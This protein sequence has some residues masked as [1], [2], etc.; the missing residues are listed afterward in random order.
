M[1][2]STKKLTRREIKELILSKIGFL[3]TCIVAIS[4]GI[5]PVGWTRKL[6]LP[7]FL[8]EC[9]AVLLLVR[10][11]VSS[12]QPPENPNNSSRPPSNGPNRKKR[13]PGEKSGRKPGGRKGHAGAA[14]EQAENPDVIE[15]LAPEDILNGPGYVLVGESRRQ[16]RDVAV[17]KAVTG[18]VSRICRDTTAGKLFKAEFP[19]R[20]KAHVTVGDKVRAMAVEPR[21]EGR[22]SCE[23]LARFSGGLGIMISE[24]TEA[25]MVKRF[26]EC[27]VVLKADGLVFKRLMSGPCVGA[28]GSPIRAGKAK[29]RAHVVA[30]GLFFFPPRQNRGI[31]AMED[32]GFLKNRTGYLAHE[33]WKACESF[34]ALHAC[35]LARLTR[36]LDRAAE[37][38]SK[39]AGKTKG[40]LPG[41]VK[42]VAH[43]KGSLPGPLLTKAGRRFRRTVKYGLSVTGGD[44]IERP[45]GEKK[46]GRVKKTPER[47]LLGRFR[48]FK[49]EILRLMS[50]LPV[51]ATNNFER[52][53]DPH[54]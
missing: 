22:L 15:D 51:P 25:N 20:A 26:E 39:Q 9:E 12:V 40:F 50:V 19:P 48:R 35:C 54:A 28:D 8:N 3:L 11:F 2:K 42:Q 33:F 16:V 41:L 31:K 23:R 4:A 36:E 10:G 13:E 53:A 37:N 17:K 24:A 5:K 34:E 29:V 52:T 49:K 14:R 1:S 18:Y 45:P 7:E 32:T 47:N 30:A 6:K 44:G 27:P 21:G 46:R 43:R 38:G